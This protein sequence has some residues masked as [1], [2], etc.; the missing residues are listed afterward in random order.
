MTWAS[1]GRVGLR[2]CPHGYLRLSRITEVDCV[3]CSVSGAQ[4]L[5]KRHTEEILSSPRESHNLA[6]AFWRCSWRLLW[7]LRLVGYAHQVGRSFHS[8]IRLAN[9]FLV[10]TRRASSIRPKLAA[11]DPISF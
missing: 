11:A 9:R 3:F 1:R 4:T 6:L 10:I 8:W 7:R 2:N 5:L